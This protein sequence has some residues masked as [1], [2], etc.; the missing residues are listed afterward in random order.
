MYTHTCTYTEIVNALCMSCIHVH[1]YVCVNMYKNMYKD[2]SW[3]WWR[4]TQ[5]PEAVFLCC[6]WASQVIINNVLTFSYSDIC[7]RPK[8]KRSGSNSQS[9]ISSHCPS[10]VVYGMYIYVCI[11]CSVNQYV[12]MYMYMYM[13]S[14]FFE[15]IA[16]NVCTCACI[17]SR[18]RLLWWIPVLD[19][20]KARSVISLWVYNSKQRRMFMYMYI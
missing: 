1:V 10:T 16:Q 4:P 19:I 7:S 12:S 15:N 18:V 9:G 8:C 11:S 13:T 17:V 14:F 20:K 6:I 5:R 2:I 3:R